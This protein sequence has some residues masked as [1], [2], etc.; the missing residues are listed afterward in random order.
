MFRLH[1]ALQKQ[2]FWN[3]QTWPSLDL[4]FHWPH[5][6]ALDAPDHKVRESAP[7]A[8]GPGEPAKSKKGSLQNQ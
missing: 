7:A 3:L 5:T 1:M 4:Q 8:F 2:S 6:G